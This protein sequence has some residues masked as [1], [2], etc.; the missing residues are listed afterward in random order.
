MLSQFYPPIIGGEEQHVRTLSLELALRGHDVVVVTLWHSG[1]KEF[2]LDQGVRLYRIRS[3]AQHMSWLFTS[4]GRQYSPPFPDPGAMFAL[5]NILTQERPQIVHAHN[6]L[7]YSF[8]PLKTWS[9]ARLIVTLH[10]YSLV[11]AKM[12]LMHEGALCKGPGVMK[13]LRCTSEFYGAPKGA[14]VLLGNS[15][16]SLFQR[17]N[18][19]RFLPVS[20][21][22]AAGNH[23]IGSS[24]P[25][26][27]VPNFIQSRVTVPESTSEPYLAQLPSEGYLLFVGALNRQKGVDVLLQAYAGIVHAPPLV[28]IGYK[29][30]EWELMSRNCPPNVFILTDW[31]HDA[32]LEAWRRSIMGLAPSV[33]PESCSTAVIEAMSAGIPVIA[34][35]IGGFSD[36]VAHK[37]TGFLVAPGNP[38]VLQQAIELLLAHADMCQRMGQAARRRSIEFQADT[39]VP[40]IEHIYREILQS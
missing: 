34:S 15:I 10:N 25:F 14:T 32:V 40:R 18:V 23:L 8:L 38:E 30:A 24:Q 39:I 6:W 4:S 29:T 16:M 11:C 5:R 27:V 21:A 7:V 37:E 22:V 9:K 3:S 26:E 1:M 33:G 17:G 35:R 13:C 2:E 12:S 31:P 19:D 20:R 36:L 28:L